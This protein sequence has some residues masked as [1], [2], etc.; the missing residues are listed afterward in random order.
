[1]RD[2]KPNGDKSLNQVTLPIF[3]IGRMK[4]TFFFLKTTTI[5]SWSW[6]FLNIFNSTFPLGNFEEA[7]RGWNWKTINPKSH[8]IEIIV[9]GCHWKYMFLFF[10]LLY[11]V[12]KHSFQSRLLKSQLKISSNK[13]ACTF[14]TC[15]NKS[16]LFYSPLAIFFWSKISPMSNDNIIIPQI[17]N[18]EAL[19]LVHYNWTNRDGSWVDHVH[20]CLPPAGHSLSLQ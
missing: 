1:M 16:L 17:G 4:P 13:A 15:K 6:Q 14:Y 20:C 3:S 10:N 18:P 8:L 7:N 9:L 12:I 5:S 19:D 11:H 2:L